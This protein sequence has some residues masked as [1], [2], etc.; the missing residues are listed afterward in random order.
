MVKGLE[1]YISLVGQY[2]YSLPSER[3]QRI[4]NVLTKTQDT[5]I[6]KNAMIGQTSPGHPFPHSLA[7]PR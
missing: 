7:V 1:R 6:V 3:L 4:S 5:I 2:G